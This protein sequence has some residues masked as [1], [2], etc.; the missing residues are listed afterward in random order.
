ME[1]LG[2]PW[3]ALKHVLYKENTE[4]CEFAHAPHICFIVWTDD[5][6]Y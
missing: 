1:G 3:V 4:P 2:Y 6:I 5:E